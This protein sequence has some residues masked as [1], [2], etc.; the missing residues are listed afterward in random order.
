MARAS[1]QEQGLAPQRGTKTVPQGHPIPSGNCDTGWQFR[2]A[3]AR[4]CTTGAWWSCDDDRSRVVLQSCDL[5]PLGRHTRSIR[6]RAR[7][8]LCNN[9]QP[10]G[11]HDRNIRNEVFSSGNG[12]SRSSSQ[13]WGEDLKRRRCYPGRSRGDTEWILSKIACLYTQLGWKSDTVVPCWSCR[14]LS[15]ESTEELNWSLGDIM[16][17]HQLVLLLVRVGKSI[18]FIR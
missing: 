5:W 18:W 14:W 2:L 9:F 15:D 6:K 11:R 16:W 4:S 12:T 8:P 17:A 3:R 10:L 13:C 7:G 1:S